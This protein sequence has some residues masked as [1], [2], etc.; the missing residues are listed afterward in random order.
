MSVQA[1]VLS[2]ASESNKKMVPRPIGY[3]PE[4][5]IAPINFSKSTKAA[6]GFV[7]SSGE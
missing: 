1:E 6:F 7:S 2:A 4:D 5:V 3:W